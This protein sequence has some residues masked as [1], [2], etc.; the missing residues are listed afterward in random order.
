MTQ[1]EPERAIQPPVPDE[2]D[3]VM[4]NRSPASTASDVGALTALTSGCDRGLLRSRMTRARSPA[5]C[6]PQGGSGQQLLADRLVHGVVTPDVF[7]DERA[8]PP[9]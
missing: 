4:P 8:L 6:A 1:A 5:G 2:A 3:V 9:Q 7:A